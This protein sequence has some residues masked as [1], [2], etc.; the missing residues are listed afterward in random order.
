[1]LYRLTTAGRETL[2]SRRV[3]RLEALRDPGTAQGRNESAP[4]KDQADVIDAG[5]L[6]RSP[7]LRRSCCAF[8]RHRAPAT[9]RR[10]RR[11]STP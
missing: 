7:R 4:V 10:W 9:V 8:T 6:F 5:G 11:R 3:A 2:K 1:M